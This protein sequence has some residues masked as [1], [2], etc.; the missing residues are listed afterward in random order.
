MSFYSTWQIAPTRS[1]P[2]PLGQARTEISVDEYDQM[3]SDQQADQQQSDMWGSIFSTVSEAIP[4]LMDT[5]SKKPGSMTAAQATAKIRAHHG[6][7]AERAAKSAASKSASSAGNSTVYIIAALV[8]V[9]LL[10]TLLILRK[11]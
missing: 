1:R 6:A 10:G 5:F 3:L 7:I 2:H 11:K 9:G 8:G 4:G